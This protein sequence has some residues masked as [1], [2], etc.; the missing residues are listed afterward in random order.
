MSATDTAVDCVVEIDDG[1]PDAVFVS[2]RD[3]VGYFASGSI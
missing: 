2:V 3:S 1:L